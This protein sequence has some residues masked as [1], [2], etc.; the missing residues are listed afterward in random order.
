[1]KTF[2]KYQELRK[3]DKAILIKTHVEET[4]Q[5]ETFWL[6]LSK[7]ELKGNSLSV[8]SEFWTDKLKEFQNPLEEESVVVES[9]A[10]DKGDKATKL[11]VEV[12][13]NENAQKLFVWIPNS[14]II[15]LEVGKDEEENKLYKVTVAKWAWESSYKDAISRQLEF[16]NKDEEKYSHKDFKLLSKVS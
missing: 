1:M 15:D 9:S 11:I 16:W 10:Y 7:I 14:K 2:A 6:P 5:E 3:S 13:F 8:D 12:L 4:A